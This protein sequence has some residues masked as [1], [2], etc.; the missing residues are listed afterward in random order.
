MS[1]E[2]VPRSDIWEGRSPGL[3]LRGG[4]LP[5]DLSHDAFDVAYLPPPS[6][7]ND[8]CENITLNSYI[9]IP[10]YVGIEYNHTNPPKLCEM[11]DRI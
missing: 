8:A 1:R 2:K 4:T 6:G 9:L 5:Y 7:Q 3:M 11:L 10:C